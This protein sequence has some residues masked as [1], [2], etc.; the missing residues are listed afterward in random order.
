MK[1]NGV[2]AREFGAKQLNVSVSAVQATGKYELP[3]GAIT[4]VALENTMPLGHIK[5]TLYFKAERKEQLGKNLAR[6]VGEVSKQERARLELDGYD[7]MY[8]GFIT[9]IQKEET[10][11]KERCKLQIELDGYFVGDM[12]ELELEGAGEHEIYVEGTRKTPCI[13]E[14]VAKKKLSEWKIEG[15]GEAISILELGKGETISIN[16]EDGTVTKGGKDAFDSVEM[17]EMPTLSPGTMTIRLAD[18][19]ASVC[20]RYYPRES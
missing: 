18:E 8:I 17:W 13:L 5:V 9:T 4:A 2:D 7:G 12:Q 11:S 6:C 19:N 3:D 16:A 14:V 10:I 15:F 20:I 1:I